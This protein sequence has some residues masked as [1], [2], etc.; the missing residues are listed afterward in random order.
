MG[1][2]IIRRLANI[3]VECSGLSR[4]KASSLNNVANYSESPKADC[5]IHCAE[6]SNRVEVNDMGSLIEAEALDTLDKLLSKGY[7]QV[8]YM[9]SAVLYGDQGSTPRKISDPVEVVD[10]YTRIKFESEKKILDHGGTVIR[11]ANLYGPA[12]ASG[13]VFNHILRQLDGRSDI[14]MQSL[15][16]VRDFLYVDD[17]ALAVCEALQ[18]NAR[19]I[20]NVGSGIGTSI[21]ELINLFQQL[22]GTQ[23]KVVACGVEKSFSQLVLDIEHTKRDLGWTPQTCLKDGIGKLIHAY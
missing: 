10:S 3:E 21:L 16:P 5:L 19:G 22:A 20:Y 15:E 23:Q 7:R 9:S 1:S 13:N 17:A 8:I 18:K 2:A 11:L 4:S 6:N 14:R 12:M